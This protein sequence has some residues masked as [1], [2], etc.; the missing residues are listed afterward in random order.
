MGLERE[1]E[2]RIREWLGG[3]TCC[4]CERPAVRFARGRFYCHVH[5][6][7]GRTEAEGDR[8]VHKHPRRMKRRR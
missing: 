2:E 4:R 7:Y 1:T 5:F 6:P 8:K 3:R